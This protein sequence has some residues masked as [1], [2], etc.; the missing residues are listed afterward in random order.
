MRVLSLSNVANKSESIRIHSTRIKR[1]CAPMAGGDNQDGLGRGHNSKQSGIKKRKRLDLEAKLAVLQ[2]LDQPGITQ[3]KAAEKF[4]VAR[5]TISKIAK[6]KQLIKDAASLPN[7]HASKKISANSRVSLLTDMVH[8]WH[9]RVETDSPDL[10]VTGEVLKAK[11]LFFRDRILENYGEH[12]KQSDIV[13][14]KAFS[15]SNGWLEKYL[16]R[17]G[18]SS[19]RRCGE[20]SSVNPAVVENR[21]QEIRDV[22]QDVLPEN[23][24]NIDESVLKHRTTSSRSYCTANSDGRGVK[25]SKERITVTPIVSAAGEKFTVKIIGKSSRPRALKNV[26]NI[27]MAFDVEYDFQSKAWQDTSSYMRLLHRIN[28]TAKQR[29]CTF[30][31]LQDNCSSHIAAAK[32]L[33]PTGSAQSVFKF[34]NLV[35]I[36]FPPNATSDCQPLDQGIIRSFKAAFRRCQLS[37]LLAE[38]ENWCCGDQPPGARFPINDHTHMRN[39]LQW[40]KSAYSEIPPNLIRRFFVKSNCLPTVTNANLNQDID[41]L[42]AESCEVD[43]SVHQLVSMLDDL[44]LEQSLSVLL[45]LD[46]S[47]VKQ[48]AEEILCIDDKNPTGDGIIDEDDIM[49]D[50]LITN[51]MIPLSVV[52]D[53]TDDIDILPVVSSSQE[54]AAITAS[55]DFLPCNQSLSGHLRDEAVNIR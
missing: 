15:A 7:R 30:F 23:I 4:G 12:L 34:E 22:L 11:A 29:S 10:N 20:H 45:G 49:L 13:A 46:G 44:Q 47:D 17:V 48:I 55:P 18:T 54:N 16:K 31:I 33:D 32:I 40:V 9:V 1:C 24:L 42:S 14:F 2:Y 6:D 41:G 21:L 5:P 37:H 52:E 3:D 39:V 36:F 50:A 53:D 25:R 43:D 27:N 19:R 51:H 28:K 35:L 26:P 38:Y 8:Q